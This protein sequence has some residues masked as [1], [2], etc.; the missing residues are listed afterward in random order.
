MR[1]NIL[2]LF[3]LLVSIHSTS[4]ADQPIMNMMPRWDGG[5]GIQV[6]AENIHH[7]DLKKGKDVIASGHSE[8]IQQLHLQGVYTWDRSVRLTFKLPYVTDARREVPVVGGTKTIEH[9]SGWGD[10]TLALP[11]KKYFNLNQ[12][13]GNWSLTPQLR[14]P[15]GNKANDYSIAKRVW[16]GGLSLGY[17]TETYDFYFATSLT[18]WT[19]ESPE[20]AEWSASFDLGWNVRNDLQLLWESDFKWDDEDAFTLSAGPAF[21]WR[22]SDRV[23]TRLEWKHDFVSHMGSDRAQYGNG[24]RINLGIG[25]VY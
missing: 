16:G 6:L 11:L 15:L 22:Y 2:R 23:H 19:F 7:S 8:T 1:P 12:R 18:A 25:L 21:Y 9:D 3:A 17:E 13:T 4:F 10:L 24:D 5:Y 20:A 14:V